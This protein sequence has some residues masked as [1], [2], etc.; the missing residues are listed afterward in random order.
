MQSRQ[1]LDLRQGQQLALTPQ[2]QQSIRFLQLSTHELSQEIAQALLDNPLLE[3]ETEYDTDGESAKVTHDTAHHDEWM[4]T[5]RVRGATSSEDDN[6]IPEAGSVTTLAEHL[7]RQLHATRLGHRDR[8]LVNLLIDELDDKGYLIPSLD[9]IAACL[10]PEL[11]VLDTELQAAL[12]LLQSFD[13]AGV[14]AGSLSDCLLLQLQTLRFSGKAQIHD[15]Q[16]LDCAIQIA[17]HHLELLA[18][19]NVNRVR[20]ALGCDIST[21]QAAHALLLGLNPRPG[22]AWSRDVADYVVP[23]VIVRKERG[24]WLASINPDV[25]PRLRVNSLYASLLSQTD[26]GEPLKGQLQQAQGLIRHVHQRFVTLER[27]AQ[28]IINS[29]HDFFEL[30]PQAMRP[31]LLRDIALLLDMHES[32]VSRATRQKYAQ[33]PWGVI[34][35]K[36]LFGTALHTEQGDATSATA[37]QAKIRAL[38]Q[39]EPA[40]KPWSD[41]KLVEQLA[42]QGVVLAR[43]TV[44]KYREAAGIEPAILRRS[45]ANTR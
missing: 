24:R 35:L 41:S 21:F 37:V 8:V 22:A 5:S 6:A 34:E 40:S 2:L 15:Q 38:I 4:A 30:G 26:G 36:Q 20:Q 9:D 32:T 13:P 28:A 43:R 19:G 18:T 7:L 45:R 44:A 12:R 33:T 39:Q 1:T 31:L 25:L 3:R 16:V 17:T 27:V 29:Q 23:E 11:Q 42:Q 10:P 14:G